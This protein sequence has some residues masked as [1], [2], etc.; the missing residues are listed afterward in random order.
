MQRAHREEVCNRG[1]RLVEH[2]RID[3]HVEEELASREFQLRQRICRHGGQQQ[4][5]EG[6]RH[7][8]EDRVEDVTGERNVVIAHQREQVAEVGCGRLLHIEARREHPE[9]IKRLHGLHDDVVHRQE[10]ER[11]HDDQEK[12]DTE[13]TPAAAA[14]DNSMFTCS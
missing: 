11:A 10:H 7:G 8:H 6:T 14:E 12:V 3:D 2:Q 1:D 9:F 5:A 13:V 4:V